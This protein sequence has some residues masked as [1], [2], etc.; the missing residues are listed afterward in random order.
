MKKY[1][2]GFLTVVLAVGMSAFTVTKQVHKK[3]FTSYIWFNVDPGSGSLSSLTDSD[4]SFNSS[5]S[6]APSTNPG[7]DEGNKNCVVGFDE[8]QVDATGQHLKPGSQPIQFT[9]YTRTSN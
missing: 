7:C 6:T 1:L 2:L 5:M 8:D 4:V 3:T 9:Y